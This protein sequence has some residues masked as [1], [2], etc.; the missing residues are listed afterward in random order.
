MG[1]PAT[2][3]VV[4]NWGPKHELCVALH[5]AD[6]RNY[7][8]AVI[9][10]WTKEYVSM[11]LNMPQAQA[12]IRRAILKIREISGAEVEGRVQQHAETAVKRVGETLD[13]E[14]LVGT[15]SKEHQDRTALK[16]LEGTGYLPG[17]KDEERGGISE[18][19]TAPLVEKLAASLELAAKAK[20]LAN[21]EEEPVDAD[22][23]VLEDG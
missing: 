1:E 11:V 18:K 21:K 3:V 20:M 14:F 4:K 17:K 23:E 2:K 8:I 13:A 10:G 15:R 16:I 5:I 19:L 7:E 12:E 6:K 9:L 22:F